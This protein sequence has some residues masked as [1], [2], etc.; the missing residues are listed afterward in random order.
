MRTSSIDRK[1]NET[2]IRLT[3]NVDG[4]GNNA[5]SVGSRN[6]SALS[7]G[8]PRAA[9]SRADWPVAWRSPGGGGVRPGAGLSDSAGC[10][11]WRPGL[12]H[13]AASLA[14]A[15]SVAPEDGDGSAF[16]SSA[17]ISSLF[18]AQ[19]IAMQQAFHTEPAIEVT[20]GDLV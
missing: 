10:G 7:R 2:Q 12:C 8:T 9:I 6:V 14:I 5:F 19:E 13:G 18:Q 1:T 11:I 20:R 3:L 16:P 15:A 4:S 17:P